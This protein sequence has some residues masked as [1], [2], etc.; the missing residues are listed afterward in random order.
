MSDDRPC[1]IEGISTIY[2]KMFG[3]MVRKLKDVRYVHHLKRNLIPVGALK[4]LSFERSIRDGVLKIIKGLI[5]ILKGVRHNNLY[6]LKGIMVTGQMVTYTNSDNN[7]NQLWHMRLVHTGDK[8]L[9]AL[10]NKVY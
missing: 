8:S 1:T 7:C 2:I 9:Q 5:V 3:R 10:A 6:Y 4:A